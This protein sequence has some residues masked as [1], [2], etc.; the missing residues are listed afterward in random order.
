MRKIFVNSYSQRQVLSLNDDVNKDANYADR[1]NAN[2]SFQP[3]YK[4]VCPGQKFL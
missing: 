3:L 2:P 4:N 1:S